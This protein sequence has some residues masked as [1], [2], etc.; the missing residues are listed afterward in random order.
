M[1]TTPGGTSRSRS[2]KTRKL[3]SDRRVTRTAADALT[4]LVDGGPDEVVAQGQQPFGVITR[5]VLPVEKAGPAVADG[6]AGR[7]VGHPGGGVEEGRFE[8][9]PEGVA[10][11][12][13]HPGVV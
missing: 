1:P 13:R 10:I 3:R 8:A 12:L 6:V 5:Q 11:G 7:Q 2:A 4:R 9:E